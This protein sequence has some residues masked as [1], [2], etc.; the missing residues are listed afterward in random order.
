MGECTPL[1]VRLYAGKI[2]PCPAITEQVLE[3][4]THT[5][6]TPATCVRSGWITRLLIWRRRG[7]VPASTAGS[8]MLRFKDSSSAQYSGTILLLLWLMFQ[9]SGGHKMK[10]MGTLRL[11]LTA[12]TQYFVSCEDYS[13]IH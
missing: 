4:I 2:T 12:H 3:T 6:G 9:T 7:M 11:R 5:M 8:L 13:D 1:S 10:G